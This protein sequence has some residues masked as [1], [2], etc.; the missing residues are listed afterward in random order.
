MISLI[1]IAN[2][3][4]ETVNTLDLGVNMHKRQGFKFPIAHNQ[5]W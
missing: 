4:G 2:V 5:C 3:G 1:R